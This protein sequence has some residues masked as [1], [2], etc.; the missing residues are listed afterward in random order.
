VPHPK[1]RRT[2]GE[3][4]RNQRKKVGLNQAELAEKAELSTVFISEVERGIK[5]L[6]VDALVRIANALQ[7][8]AKTLLEGV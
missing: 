3:A 8:P 4:I 7:V 6:S 2:L 1:H 5:T